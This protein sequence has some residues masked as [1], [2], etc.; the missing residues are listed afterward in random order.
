ML[1]PDNY[2]MEIFK[3][4]SVTEYQGVYIRLNIIINPPNMR[5]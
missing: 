4:F 3:L 1:N 5:G 2:A